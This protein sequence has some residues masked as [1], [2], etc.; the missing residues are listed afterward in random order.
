MNYHHCM[1]LQTVQAVSHADCIACRLPDMLPNVDRC[2]RYLCSIH[3]LPGSITYYIFYHSLVKDTT[4]VSML[5]LVWEVL[6]WLSWRLQGSFYLFLTCQ[7]FP[8]SMDGRN[9][10]ANMFRPKSLEW[11]PM[12]RLR[13]KHFFMCTKFLFLLTLLGVLPDWAI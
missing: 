12:K 2:S 10:F 4:S 1:W 6:C 8:V 5:M 7:P 13:N 11:S 9:V 3:S